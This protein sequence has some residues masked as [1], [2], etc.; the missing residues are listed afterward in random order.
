MARVAYISSTYPDYKKC[1][2]G[3]YAGYLTKALAE[4]G[5]D[6]HVITTALPEIRSNLARVT[7]HK[8]LESWTL[9]EVPKLTELFKKIK[10]D[11]IHI[12]HPTSIAGK[13]T[14]MLVN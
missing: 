13:K 1:G 2:V 9:S 7:I 12:N 10:P 4:Q 6:M 11:I 14:K 8:I 5:H 3:I